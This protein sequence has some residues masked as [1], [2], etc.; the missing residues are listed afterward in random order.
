MERRRVFVVIA[1]ALSFGLTAGMLGAADDMNVALGGT[2]TQSSVASGGVPERAIDGNTNGLWSSGTITHT[3]NDAMP[4][5]QVDLG[6]MYSLTRIVLWT[7]TDSCCIA[8]LTNFKVSV[9]DDAAQEVWSDV[10]YDDCDN[11][12]YPNPSLE[13]ILPDDT[14]GQ[15]V[16]VDLTGCDAAQRYLSLAEVQ[17]FSDLVGEPLEIQ[18][19]PA[20]VRVNEGRTATLS[21]LAYGELPLHYEWFKGDEEIP[22]SDADTLTI[23]PAMKSDAGMY[24]VV[25]SNPATPGGVESDPAELI[26]TSKNL[27]LAGTAWQSSEAN[28]GAPARAIDGNVD[29]N[30]AVAS[31][32]HTGGGD[33]APTWEVALPIEGTIEMV[34]LWNRVDCCQQRL[35]NFR[36]TVYD[37]ARQV[38]FEE[39][40][41]TDGIDSPVASEPFEIPLP[42]DTPGRYVRVEL[43]G[44]NAAPEFVLSLAEVEVLGE[45][46]EPPPNPNLARKGTAWQSSDYSSAYPASMAI[47][48]NYG[49]FTHTAGVDD[50]ATWEVNLGEMTDISE[51]ILYNR[52]SCCGSRLRDITVSVL[53][54]AA[55]LVYESKLLNP[56]NT[57]YTYPNGPATLSVNLVEELGAAV[58]GQ[59]VRIA[60]TPDPDLS[61]SGGEGDANEANALS[62][63]EVAI[64]AAL[65]PADGDT[66]CGGLTLVG[67]K[68]GQPGLYRLVGVA[69]DDTDDVPQYTFTVNDGVNPATSIGPRQGDFAY[70]ALTPADWTLSVAADDDLIRCADVA[71][72]AVCEIAF[73]PAPHQDN[74]AP[75]GIAT[76]STTAYD[77]V[78]ERAIDGNTNGLWA[79]ASVSHTDVGTLEDVPWWEVDLQILY[80]LGR[81][82]LWSRLDVAWERLTN[83]RVSVLDEVRDVVF[84]ET[85]FEDGLTWPYTLSE[86]FEI[87]LPK[88]T[89]GQYVR[90]E[91]LGPDV[92]GLMYL[93]LAEVEVYTAPAGTQFIR[94]DTDGNGIYT[95]G[96]GIQVLERLFADREAYTSDCEDTGDLDDNGI[97]TIGDAVWLFNYLFAEG[98]LKKPPY[99]PADTCG[100]DPTPETTLGCNKFDSCQ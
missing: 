67:P 1:A 70:F 87:Q 57:G 77:G 62:M 22:D 23:D 97:L 17:V 73:T 79:A 39:D 42:A 58:Q 46:P 21:V 83:F 92:K 88:G 61:G 19:Q 28:S 60:R 12:A 51:I 47:D 50:A 10:F 65:C 44:P 90:V 27:A 96:D 74:V 81:I 26:V 66:H 99:P 13:I 63:G 4:W 33:V 18:R 48:G 84:E 31:T 78:P 64:Y 68:E 91:R 38:T 98:E 5:W 75:L 41:F 49:N 24:H 16:R 45:S 76:Q 53:D 59:I 2:A 37:S 85:F 86:G 30:W 100:L 80:P 93:S 29:G 7:R 14:V 6:K 34:V 8:R 71:G 15:V 11:I 55:G 69:L 54:D 82:V 3:G 20:N 32:T 95:L 35:S 56:E 52:T 72:D 89:E 40:F 94:G 25:V 9:F 36:V 43:L